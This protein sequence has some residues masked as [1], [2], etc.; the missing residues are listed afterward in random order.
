MSKMEAKNGKEQLIFILDLSIFIS[1][2][3][4]VMPT[5][6]I[7]HPVSIYTHVYTCIRIYRVCML[8][9]CYI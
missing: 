4:H 5:G 7:D 9:I 1:V 8:N 3:I 2:N 6:V